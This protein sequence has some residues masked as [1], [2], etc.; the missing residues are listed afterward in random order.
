MNP[1]DTMQAEVQ[2]GGIHVNMEIETET[3]REE[4]TCESRLEESR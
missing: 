3:E 1:F 4:A 2:R